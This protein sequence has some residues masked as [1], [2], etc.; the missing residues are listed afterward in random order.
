VPN[1][2]INRFILKYHRLLFYGAWFLLYVLQAAATGLL[3]DETYYWVYSRFLNWGYFDHP[4][5]VALLIKAGHAISPSGFGLRLPFAI[6]STASLWMIEKLLPQKDDLLFYTIALSLGLLQIGGIIAIPDTPL[7]FFT[8]LF[9]LVYKKILERPT[10]SISILL[11]LTM[12]LLLYSKYHGVLIIFFTLLSNPKLFLRSHIYIAG[13]TGLLLFGP[14]LYWQYMN[15]FP[16]IQFHLL[17]RNAPEYKLNFTT[18]YVLGQ[19]LLAGPIVGIPLLWWAFAK[20]PA[21]RYE[22]G[23]K[24]NLA[25]IYLFFLLSTLKGRVEANWTV[26]AFVPLIVLSHQYILN[27]ENHRRWLARLAVLTIAVMV[28]V[29]MHLI[30]DLFPSKFKKEEY[31]FNKEWAQAVDARANGLPVFFTDSYQRASKYWFYTGKPSFSLN[32]VDYRRNNFNFWPMEEKFFGQKVYAVYQ[33][34]KQDYY[35]DSISTPKGIYLG[36]VIENYFSFSRIRI[37]TMDKLIAREGVVEARLKILS[38]DGMLQQI[39]APFDTAR[40][41]LTVYVKDS[42]VQNIPTNIT[43]SL[44]KQK[45]QYVDAR[46]NVGLP[47]GK[48]VIRFS[49]S[50]CID[51]WPTINSTVLHLKVE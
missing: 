33:G 46:F 36:R 12:A 37:K 41:H 5:M 28:F 49:I 22:R 24:F 23:L 14:H 29:R 18:D 44:I 47:E 4:P 2:S 30:V 34:R 38:D 21:S 51:N 25:G 35:H 7:L 16:S 9:F 39:K 45:K 17:E 40:V 32:T 42:V 20:K 26:P 11:G 48:Y 15:G 50:S 19:L 1:A 3:H 10:V 31:Q 13:I 43:V 8:V 27:K 6:L